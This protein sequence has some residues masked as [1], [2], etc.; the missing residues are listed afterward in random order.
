MTKIP[1]WKSNSRWI[2]ADAIFFYAFKRG[3]EKNARGSRAKTPILR[4]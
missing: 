4:E 2:I 1:T 3:L